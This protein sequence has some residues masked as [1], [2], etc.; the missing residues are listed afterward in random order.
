MQKECGT[1]RRGG[2]VQ[3]R[4]TVKYGRIRFIGLTGR[5]REKSAA[6]AGSSITGRDGT[7]RRFTPSKQQPLSWR[8]QGTEGIKLAEILYTYIYISVYRVFRT[9]IVRAYSVHVQNEIITTY[10]SRSPKWKTVDIDIEFN[11]KNESKYNVKNLRKSSYYNTDCNEMKNLNFACVWYFDS[12]T[13]F[14]V[15]VPNR[16]V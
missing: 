14:D 6:A 7:F 3:R 13:H 1:N 9:R 2:G 8:S 16:R 5:G 11:A 10:A 12:A 15:V 4:K